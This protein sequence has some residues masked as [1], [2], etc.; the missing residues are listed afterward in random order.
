MVHK[1]INQGMV[2]TITDDIIP[3]LDKSVHGQPGKQELEAQ[4]LLQRSVFHGTEKEKNSV[5]HLP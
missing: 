3:E 2:K 4:T 1:T 5:L